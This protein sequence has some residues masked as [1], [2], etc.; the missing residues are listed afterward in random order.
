[1]GLIYIDPDNIVQIQLSLFYEQQQRKKITLSPREQEVIQLLAS[2]MRDLEIASKLF[3]SDR[4]VKFHINNAVTKLNSST[5]I[6]AVYQAYTQG[7][8]N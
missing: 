8:I 7:L 2:G 6:Q 1:M 4:T 3:I 5:R